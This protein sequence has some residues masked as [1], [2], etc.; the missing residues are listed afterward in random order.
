MLFVL[1][2]FVLELFVFSLITFE[3]QSE[4][5]A[6]IIF[7]FFVILTVIPLENLFQ[8]EE[9][10]LPGIVPDGPLPALNK[11]VWSGK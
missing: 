1:I 3:F 7:S 8:L 9:P 2:E 11:M 5:A 6:V 10:E 4:Q